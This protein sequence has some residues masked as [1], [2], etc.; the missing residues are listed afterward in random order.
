[1]FIKFYN[2]TGSITFG[3]KST[4]ASPFKLIAAEGLTP[5]SKT[6]TAA[7]FS[8]MP[9]Q[10]TTETR[11]RARIITLSGDFP[12]EKGDVTL[13]SNLLRILD[14]EGWLCIYSNDMKRKIKC[15]CSDFAEGERKGAFVPF[16][17]QF[18][19]DNPYFED[20]EPVKRYIFKRTD[21]I[22]SSF[23][24]PGIFTGRISK[25]DI[26]YTGSAKA[27]PIIKIRE[28]SSQISQTA[29]GIEIYNNTH[30]EFIK[31]IYTPE[32][33]EEITI[34]I[35]NRKIYNNKGENL[36]M[37]MSNDT[38]LDE[39]ALYPG[40]NEIEVINNDGENALIVTCEFANKYIEAVF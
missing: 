27:E 22:N 32:N 34:D 19:C 30:G 5:A 26:L 35:A 20:F 40:E 36:I 8:G 25:G 6:F 37:Y 9:G 39:F 28:F 21:N 17:I 14:S 23:K 12:A 13:Y 3:G 33:D 7:E 10:I 15:I 16:V 24:L 11:V 4:D 2:D 29:G 18:T 38:Y 31:L 1:M